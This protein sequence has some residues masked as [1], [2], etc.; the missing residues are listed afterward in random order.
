MKYMFFDRCDE[1]SAHVL[2]GFFLIAVI[3]CTKETNIYRA[4]S[5][6]FFFLFQHLFDLLTELNISGYC[7]TDPI[8]FLDTKNWEFVSI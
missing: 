5:I 7:F 8:Q 4:S 2:K 6:T 1:F 3:Q